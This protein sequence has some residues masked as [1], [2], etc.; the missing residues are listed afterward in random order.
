MP[1]NADNCAQQRCN[2]IKFAIL[3]SQHIEYNSIQNIHSSTLEKTL[4]AYSTRHVSAAST[5]V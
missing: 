5:T 2:R 4:K 3:K 1:I